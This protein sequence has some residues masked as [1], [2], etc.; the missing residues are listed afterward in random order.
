[1]TNE[2]AIKQLEDLIDNRKHLI[3]CWEEYAPKYNA[4]IQALKIAIERMKTPYRQVFRVVTPG[5]SI[6][7]PDDP[8]EDFRP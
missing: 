8:R 4:D 3:V 5:G 1:M 7:F 2:E 6:R